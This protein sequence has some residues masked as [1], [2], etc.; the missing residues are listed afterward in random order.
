MATVQYKTVICD[1]CNHKFKLKPKIMKIKEIAEGV[2]KHSFLCPKCKHQYV[3]M[4]QDQ[5]FKNN[6]NRMEV[7]RLQASNL[8]I[9][10]DDYKT[11][12]NEH[13]KLQ[14]RNLEISTQY[15]KIYGS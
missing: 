13:N 6:L 7:I 2:E 8:K 9:N 5:E 1:E 3:V 4:Y 14:I 11:L 12:L 10:N 15:K